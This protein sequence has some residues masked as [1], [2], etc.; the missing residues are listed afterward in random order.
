MV[1][2]TL[3]AFLR[4]CQIVPLRS[5]YTCVQLH[6]KCHPSSSSSSYYVSIRRLKNSMKRKKKK[7]RKV[8]FLR[9]GKYYWSRI[10]YI[11]VLRKR[12]GSFKFEKLMK[13]D[14]RWRGSIWMSKMCKS[15]SKIWY[16]ICS[17]EIIVFEK[18]FKRR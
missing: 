15:R 2:P 11:L 6:R 8:L 17:L 9:I 1:I 12:G 13:F 5:I 10:F 3:T 14:R 16:K 7:E 4:P 18:F